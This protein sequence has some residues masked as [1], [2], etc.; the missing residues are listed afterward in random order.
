MKKALLALSITFG[1]IIALVGGVLVWEHQSKLKLE[2]QVNDYLTNCDIQSTS[3]D[4]HGRPY[5]IFAM[6]DSA[7]LTY[8]NLK[9]AEGIVQ[10]QALI[11]RLTKGKADKMDRFTTFEFPSEDASPIENEDGSFSNKALVAGKEMTFNASIK[12]STLRV[13]GN[14]KQIGEIKLD[15]DATISGVVANKQGVL[16]DMEYTSAN[17]RS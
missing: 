12:G 1:L 9:Q 8:V 10:D 7:D 5:I 2:A 17:C 15:R 13:T 4:V 14:G 16:V 3:I 6:E 11:H